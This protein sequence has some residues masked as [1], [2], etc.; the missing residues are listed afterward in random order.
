MEYLHAMNEPKKEHR[1]AFPGVVQ[2]APPQVVN[3]QISKTPETLI[4][5]KDKFNTY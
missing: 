3:S 2:S 5:Y 1:G 4:S